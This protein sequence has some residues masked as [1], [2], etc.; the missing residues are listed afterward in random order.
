MTTKSP[1]DVWDTITY[2]YDKLLY[3]L[4]QRAAPKK[5]RPYAERL[6]RLLSEADPDQESV[7][8]QECRSLI[9]EAR[10]DLKNA[11]KHRGHEIRLIRR[12]HRLSQGKPYEAIALRDYGYSDLRD[13]LTILAML[14][15]DS[16]SLDKA[17]ETLMESKELCQCHGISF[18][19]KDLLH[20]YVAKT[21]VNHELRLEV[22]ENGSYSIKCLP[23][24]AVEFR[25]KS[26]PQAIVLPSQGRTRVERKSSGLSFPPA[27]ANL[28]LSPPTSDNPYPLVPSLALSKRT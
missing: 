21:N 8:G 18:D 4:Y 22:S 28:P 6:E 19:D 7:F 20:E 1:V 17:I 16:G 5:A 3:W 26:P 14:Y 24:P 23:V 12:L 2:L 27:P 25:K 13:R 11:I 9:C 10:G 15:H